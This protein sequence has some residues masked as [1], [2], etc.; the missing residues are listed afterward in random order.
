MTKVYVDFPDFSYTNKPAL[1]IYFE[2]CNMNCEYCDFKKTFKLKKLNEM[3]ITD[4]KKFMITNY[5]FYDIVIISGGEPT[6]ENQ[7]LTK[8]IN[9]MKYFDKEIHL[10]TNL[11]ELDN[12]SIVELVDKIYVDVKGTTIDEIVKIAKIS[13]DEAEILLNKY[14]KFKNNDKFIF[15]LNEKIGNKIKFK[16]IMRYNTKEV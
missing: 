4:V 5:N 14:I 15:R 7:E 3:S 6:T 1:T 13:K 2:D 12:T 10:Y 11:L 9:F 8:L 16:N